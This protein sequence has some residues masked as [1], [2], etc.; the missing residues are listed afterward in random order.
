MLISLLIAMYVLGIRQGVSIKGITDSMAGALKDIG[1]I[2]LIIGGAGALKQVMA[3][4]GVSDYIAASLGG[5]QVSAL[6]LG[7]GIAALVRIAIGS[8]TIAALTSAGIIA[9]LAAQQGIDPNLMV[10][11]IGAG[12]LILSHVNDSGFW[13]FKEY[14]NLS[15]KDT[16]KSWTV[17]ETIVAVVGLIG[18]ILIDMMR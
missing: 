2:L 14:F 5:V 3:D 1:V 8:A 13:L 18:V 12:S 10:I 15:I 11:G 17:M 6:V 7:W 9:P 4:S 16:L